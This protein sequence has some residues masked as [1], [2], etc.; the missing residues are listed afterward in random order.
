MR[1]PKEVI[2]LGHALGIS[3]ALTVLAMATIYADDGFFYYYVSYSH[4]AS[5]HLECLRESIGD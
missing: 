5:L 2:R 3:V 1:H 4:A